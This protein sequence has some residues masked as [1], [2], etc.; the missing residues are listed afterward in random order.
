MNGPQGPAEKL[1][2]KKP[3]RPELTFKEAGQNSK[4]DRDSGR[5]PRLKQKA[6]DN[7]KVDVVDIK[8]EIDETKPPQS[9]QSA[10]TSLNCGENQN[11]LQEVGQ[12]SKPDGDSGKK[13]G[14]KQ[15]KENENENEKVAAVEI[16]QEIN[17][18]VPRKSRR[19]AN[20]SLTSGEKQNPL[21]EAGRNSKPNRDSGVRHGL[22][23]TNNSLKKESATKTTKNSGKRKRE[24]LEENAGDDN[25]IDDIT[26][27]DEN[28]PSKARSGIETNTA[29]RVR[30]SLENPNLYAYLFFSLRVLTVVSTR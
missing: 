24:V 8:H 19:S 7:E 6:A 17:E 18:A 28:E 14:L 30:L 26:T 1:K 2:Q 25:V 15:N 4:P 23:Q 9:R 27:S 10:N 11:P 22:K 13:P 12:N 16:K 3:S 21:Q 29:T 20:T 5:K